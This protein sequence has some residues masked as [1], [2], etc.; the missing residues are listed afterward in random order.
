MN[1]PQLNSG[2]A[3]GDVFH[4]RRHVLQF[5]IRSISFSHRQDTMLQSFS[6]DCR[7]FL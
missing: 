5:A 7:L 1:V 3:C 6:V 2:A 4:Q